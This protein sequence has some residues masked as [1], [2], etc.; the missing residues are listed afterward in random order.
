M[1]EERRH[2]EIG[3]AMFDWRRFYPLNTWVV[4][5]ADPRVK[6]TKGG[7]ELPDQLLLAER[8][9]E[10]T[11]HLLKVGSGAS[12]AVGTVIEPGMRICYRGFLKD[13]FQEFEAADGCPVFLLKAEDILAIIDEDTQMGFC[14]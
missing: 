12:K 7:I 10:G 2:E 1:G 13:A 9:M 14:S 4:V 3:V 5:K 6:K 8:K 11:G